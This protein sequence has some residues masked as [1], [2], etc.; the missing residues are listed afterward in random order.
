M[1][2]YV[3]QYAAVIGRPRYP[4]ED[5]NDIE[6]RTGTRIYRVHSRREHILRI[7]KLFGRQIKCIYTNQPEQQEWLK[8]KQREEQRQNNDSPHS[9]DDD[10]STQQNS[11]TD[12][13]TEEKQ[14]TQ[15]TDSETE[16]TQDNQKHIAKQHDLEN[17]IDNQNKRKP[18]KMTITTENAINYTS[19]IED[20][21]DEQNEKTNN[22]SKVNQHQINNQNVTQR[23]KRPQKNQ[24]S[25]TKQLYW[26]DNLP[27]Q[28]SQENYPPLTTNKNQKDSQ[29]PN[30]NIQSSQNKIIIEETPISQQ[31][32]NEE[33]D[34]DFPTPPIP[35]QQILVPRTSRGRPPPTAPGR[36]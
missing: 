17:N 28:L 3:Q 15:N 1:T 20:N 27:R 11:N 21:T 7:V 22:K 25:K 10:D 4:T 35:S 19:D 6:Y 29:S 26:I 18:T 31:P 16:M 36:P 32:V 8:R 13:E 5:I 30:T 23:K 2:Q 9:D 33:N 24:N 34:I 14:G 12:T